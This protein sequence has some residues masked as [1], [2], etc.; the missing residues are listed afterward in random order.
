VSIREH[1][2][3]RTAA[4]W[5]S[6]AL[7]RD[8]TQICFVRV[9]SV[10]GSPSG[11][12]LANG[13]TLL[14]VADYSGLAFVDAARAEA[15]RSGAVLGTITESNAPIAFETAVAKDGR[16]A[17][18]ANE[19]DGT[20]GV[21][22]LGGVGRSGTPPASF[23]GQVHVST[24]PPRQD[25]GAV[26]LTL[27]PDGR[28]L[29]VVSRIDTS[30]PSVPQQ[31][32]AGH[33]QGVLSVV[34]VAQAEHIASGA[35]LGRVR[36]GCGPVRVA[37]SGTGDVAWVTAQLGN[38]VLAFRTAAIVTDQA[39]ALVASAHVDRAPTGLALIEDDTVVAVTSSNRYLAPD[40]PQTV[41]LLDARGVLAG[42]GSTLG[43]IPAG[44]F[45]RELAASGDGRTLVLTNYNSSTVQV[46]DVGHLPRPPG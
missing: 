15:G 41:T 33:P 1:P 9:V 24:G 22:D 39:H 25:S 36:A 38:Q 3:W 6:V 2:K 7:R 42:R 17:F 21:V 34:D 44:A 29:Y 37:L 12:A 23:L 10:P 27:S 13:D 40:I 8:A 18:V 31:E 35:V 14:V 20:I 16:Y 11:L 19:G 5:S 32:C 30:D 45:P 4:R 28:L 43:T 46:F 26:D